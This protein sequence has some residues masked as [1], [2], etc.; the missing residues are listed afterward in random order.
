MDDSHELR[1]R[2]GELERDQ[3]WISSELHDGLLQSVVA[4]HMAAE[5]LRRKWPAASGPEP[6]ELGLL[7]QYL[8][9]AMSEGRILL[10]HTQPEAISNASLTAS[11]EALVSQLRSERGCS[12]ISTIRLPEG[13]SPAIQ[14]TVYRLLQETLTNVRRH[15][16]AREV[17]VR[18]EPSTM[19]V[20]LETCDDGR[21]FDAS[22]VGEG[23]FGLRGMQRRVEMMG[24][25]FTLTT[26]PGHGTRVLVELPRGGPLR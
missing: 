8:Q 18:I 7:L 5:S 21:G 20:T 9:Q 13:L 1:T 12:V 24:G 4:A 16:D 26:Q 23:H 3:Q 11:L 19:G 25:R 2:L 6:A 15:S 22:R 10:D 17:R 14:R